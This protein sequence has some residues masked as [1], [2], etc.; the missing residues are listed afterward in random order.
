MDWTA[1]VRSYDQKRKKKGT[2]VMQMMAK[3]AK[4]EP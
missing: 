1:L 3:V 4:M 2:A